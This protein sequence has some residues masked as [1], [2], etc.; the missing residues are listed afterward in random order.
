VS[1]LIALPLYDLVCAVIRLSIIAIIPFDLTT[2]DSVVLPGLVIALHAVRGL[3]ACRCS[4]HKAE[5]VSKVDIRP[6]IAASASGLGSGLGLGQA[7]AVAAAAP[8]GLGLSA[9]S[10]SAQTKSAKKKVVDAFVALADVASSADAFV[11][12]GVSGR[13]ARSV[14]AADHRSPD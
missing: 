11:L 5:T 9:V 3:I 14:E 1:L 2:V 8:S 10:S 4:E 12:V 7:A 6:A 13:E